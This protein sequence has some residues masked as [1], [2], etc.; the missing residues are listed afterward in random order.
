MRIGLIDTVAAAAMAGCSR[1][2][3]SRAVR[4]GDL[5]QAGTGDAQTALFAPADVR[6][7]VEGRAAGFPC[8][9][10]GCTV[11]NLRAGVLCPSCGGR[12]ARALVLG[13]I[14]N[15]RRT[16]P[17]ADVATPTA[18]T[19]ADSRDAIE[20]GKRLWDREWRSADGG[21]DPRG[22]WLVQSGRGCWRPARVCG[23]LLPGETPSA[24]IY[25]RGDGT[26][27]ERAIK[28]GG[29]LA[30][31]PRVPNLEAK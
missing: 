28:P 17:R 21:T 25:R 18:P 22:F 7:W 10:V 24:L 26:W 27:Q 3:V 20:D 6:A 9:G 5:R 8:G 11:R 23:P 2:I 31:A 13:R 29:Y 1:G 15:A 16:P 30:D 4:L 12:R 14:G 19:N